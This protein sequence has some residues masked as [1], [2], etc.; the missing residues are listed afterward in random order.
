M[1]WAVGEPRV[2]CS[3]AG[4]APGNPALAG[5][6]AAAPSRWERSGW[7]HSTQASAGRGGPGHSQLLALQPGSVA[8]AQHTSSAPRPQGPGEDQACGWTETQCD[9]CSAFMGTGQGGNV[10]CS[11]PGKRMS[12]RGIKLRSH[13]QNLLLFLQ[14]LFL[15]LIHVEKSQ[16]SCLFRGCRIHSQFAWDSSRVHEETTAFFQSSST[17]GQGPAA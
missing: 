10:L 5:L 4:S 1:L 16:S 14:K 2:L 11:L 8:P 7:D 15:C 6:R 3:L 17:Q 9:R 13:P 12:G